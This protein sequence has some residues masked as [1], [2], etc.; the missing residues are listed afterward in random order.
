M[1]YLF[2]LLFTVSAYCQYGNNLVF[3]G[4]FATDITGWENVSW[5]TWEWSAGKLHIVNTAGVNQS[6]GITAASRP[7]LVVDVYRIQITIAY[8][9]GA[10]AL[11]IRVRG[12]LTGGIISSFTNLS[13]GVHRLIYTEASGGL[14][15]LTFDDASA[16][17]L[18]VDD[19]TI[20]QKLDTLYCDGTN[21]SDTDT[22]TVKTLA[23]MFT[24]RGAHGG[25]TL[26]I[27]AGTYAESVTLDS[28]LT[29][30]QFIGGPTFTQIDA[31]SKT[32]TI[33]GCYT[34]TIANDGNVTYINPC[35]TNN[36]I[37]SNNFTGFPEFPDFINDEAIQ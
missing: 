23:E 15:T 37:Y 20:R 7:T 34:G 14:K 10:T 31:N 25:G 30:I 22:D 26:I 17:D 16:T 32:L 13:A 1:K 28:S 2:I 19:V 36:T 33:D 9:S 29:K 3:N 6:G 12:T 18:T 4:D 21:G 35:V 24:T 11:N 27:L 5:D 8:N